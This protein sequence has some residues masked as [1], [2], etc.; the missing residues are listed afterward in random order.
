LFLGV[1]AVNRRLSRALSGVLLILAFV[2]QAGAADR[3]K[4]LPKRFQHWID[5]EVPYIIDHDERKQ[6]LSLHTDV[7]REYFIEQFWKRLNPTPQAEDN[8]YKDEH[9]RRLAYANEHFGSAEL[10][11]GW[12]TDKGR[13][14]ILLGA[15]KQIVTYPAA[16]NVRPMEIWFY[17][18]PSPA[19]PPYFSLIFYKRSIGEDYTLYSP[20]QDG[21]A[22][23]VSTLEALNDQKRA[24]EILRKSLGD[25]VARTSLSLL[26]GDR[27]D[28]T[29]YSPNLTSDSLI[30]QI[31]SLPFNPMTKQIQMEAH[32]GESVTTSILLGDA[33]PEMSYAVFCNA[34]GASTVSYLLKNRLGD[35][36]LIEEGS[37]KALHYDLTLKSTVLTADGKFVYEQDDALTGKVT[38]TQAVA[39]RQKRFGAEARLPLAPGKYVVV[40]TLTNNLNHLATRQHV[41]VTV[42]ETKTGAIGISPLVAYTAPAPVPDAL[43]VLPFSASRYRFTPR[44]AETVEIRQGEKLPLVFQLWLGPKTVEGAQQ[45]TKVH[46]RYVFGAEAAGRAAATTENEEVDVADRDAAGNLLTGHTLDT[47]TLEP[48]TY[49]VVVGANWDGAPQT[50]Y[51]TMTLHVRNLQEQL[52]AWTAYGGVAADVGAVDDL[53]RGMSAEVLGEEGAAKSFYEK[54]L[55]EGPGEVRALERL[56]DLATRRKETETLAALGTKPILADDAVPQQTLL[57]ISTAM[58]ASGNAKGAAKMLEVQLKLQAPTAALYTEL[59]EASE[60][61]GDTRRAKEA[62]GLAAGLK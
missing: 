22:A 58:R 52:E 29:D 57:A 61:A 15:P 39:A 37:D 49:R 7:E 1:D 27:V 38:E 30:H 33:A 28:L 34:A 11:D 3:V 26:P 16:R 48:G 31:E 32:A 5:E 59:A 45:G 43:G 60:A 8:P 17:Q 35:P 47:S 51:Q 40:A 9:Y 56:A 13:M 23:L 55:K 12:R 36:R 44:G 24:L 21:P 50:S 42:P 62:R 2:M 25:E 19:L 41:A 18:S 46:V 6:F 20:Y 10:Q 54:A 53:K 4:D 14:Y